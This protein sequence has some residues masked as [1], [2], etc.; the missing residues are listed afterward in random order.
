MNIR[1]PSDNIM[2]LTTNVNQQNC[3]LQ[4]N[5]EKWHSNNLPTDY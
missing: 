2:L 4:T 3:S 1:K 5:L